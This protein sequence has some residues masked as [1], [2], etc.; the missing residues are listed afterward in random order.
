MGLLAIGALIHRFRNVPKAFW[1]I[2]ALIWL[3]EAP[4]TTGTPRFRA[5]LDPWI[6]LLAGSAIAATAQGISRRRAAAGSAPGR[7]NGDRLEH[8]RAVARAARDAVAI[9]QTSIARC[10]RKGPGQGS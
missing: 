5:A 6:I 3:S 7:S 2:P 9:S 10:G 4:I 8:Q 1:L